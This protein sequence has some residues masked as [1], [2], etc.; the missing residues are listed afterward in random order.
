MSAL[1][2]FG[3][4]TRV[5]RHSATGTVPRGPRAVPPAV[6]RRRRA[7]LLALTVLSAL[8][9]L[10]LVVRVLAPGGWS[11]WEVLILVCAVVQLP[12]FGLSVATGL[13]GG[14][15]ALFARDPAAAVL[16]ALRGLQPEAPIR[17]RTLLAICVRDE[18]MSEVLPPVERLLRALEASG[19][20]A[21][22]SIGVLSDTARPENA[23]EEERAMRVLAAAHRPGAVLYRRRLSNEGYKAGN[24]MEFLDNHARD[25]DFMM[26]LD[27]DSEMSAATVLRMVRVAEAD[28]RCAIL[29]S[30]IAGAPARASFGRLT[31][32]GARHGGRI[33]VYGQ[34][35]WQDDQGP[36]WG[37]NALVRIAPFRA[38]CRLPAMADGTPILSHDYVEAAT[39]QGAGWAV[40]V[41][42]EDEG[43]L[44]A[45]PPHAMAYLKRELRWAAGNMQWMG[46]LRERRLSTLGRFQMAQAVAYYLLIPFSFALMPLAAINAA[47]GGAAGTPRPWLLLLLVL[48]WGLPQL[49]KFAGYAQA[50]LRPG[51]GVTRGP[52]LAELLFTTLFEPVAGFDRVVVL[53]RLLLGGGRGWPGQERLERDLEW[54]EAVGYFWPHTLCGLVMAALFASAGLF[55]LL[56]ALPFIGGLILAVPFAVVT[57]VVSDTRFPTGGLAES[58]EKVRA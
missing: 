2:D 55:P 45:H 35:W 46:L 25:F 31:G 5:D 38:H 34:A 10:A 40:R 37:H 9:M 52:M 33:W 21:A 26:V 53:G 19:H 51:P 12:W 49:A 29:Q 7:L 32:F 44:E 23:A 42:P 24:V 39:L 36:Y 41:L 27:A 17:T 30:N 4:I 15:I 8:A 13:I 54:S 50:I 11:A 6:L 58:R 20:G 57:S 14:A 1:P 16:P 47:T 22:F 48:L 56:A 43:S 18:P 3:A 28:E